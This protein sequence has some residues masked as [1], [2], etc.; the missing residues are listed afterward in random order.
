MTKHKSKCENY[1]PPSGPS[2]GACQWIFYLLSPSPGKLTFQTSLL[3]VK[4]P[5]FFLYQDSSIT[6]LK[7]YVPPFFHDG[8]C[9]KSEGEIV[10][11]SISTSCGLG[12]SVKEIRK[13]KMFALRRRFIPFYT[14]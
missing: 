12:Y 4:T 8:S 11:G 5:H 9:L 7:L 2:P 13:L 1:V 6:R 14:L 10:L 3:V